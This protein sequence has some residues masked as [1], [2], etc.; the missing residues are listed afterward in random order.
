M[1]RFID[2]ETTGVSQKDV[3]CSAALLEENEL[4]FEYVNEGKKI[5]PSASCVHNITNEMIQNAQPFKKTKIY[6]KLQEKS[7]SIMI[8]FHFGFLASLLERYGVM[9][10]QSYVD[11]QRCTKHLIEDLESYSLNFLRYE[12]RL[13]KKEQTLMQKYGMSQCPLMPHDAK[14]DVIISKL[15][16]EELLELA[17]LEELVNLSQKPVL[18]K[19]FEFGKY[20]GRYIE[21]IAMVDRGYLEWMLNSFDDIDEDL[22]YTLEY[23]L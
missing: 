1:L 19:K 10:E 17:P 2:I 21:E 6:A 11:L 7:D 3:I 23:Y 22:A 4:L 14:S 20:S 12:L 13:Y 5:P 18:L 9:I 8:G 15:L 16:F